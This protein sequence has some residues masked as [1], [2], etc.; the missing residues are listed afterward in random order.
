MVVLLLV[1]SMLCWRV[2][3]SQDVTGQVCALL[4][5]TYRKET[6]SRHQLCMVKAQSVN[7]NHLMSG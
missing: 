7:V 3:C 5:R 4:Q 6:V 2:C 1:E